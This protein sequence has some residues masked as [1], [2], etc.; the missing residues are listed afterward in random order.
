MLFRETEIN[1]CHE[2]DIHEEADVEQE[3]AWPGDD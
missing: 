3:I 2:V 1:A